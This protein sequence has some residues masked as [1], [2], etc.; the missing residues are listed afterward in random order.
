VNWRR[1]VWVL[2]VF[3][4]GLALHNFA[5]AELWAAGVR[6]AGLSVVSAWKEVLLALALVLVVRERRRLPFDGRLTDWLALL[7]GAFVVLYA[8]I[9]QSWLD[10]GATHK[11]VLFGLRNDLIPV[12]AYFLGR[13]L[14]LTQAEIRRLATTILA[15]GVGVAAFGLID[16]FAIPLSWWRGSGAPNWYAYQ[17]GLTDPG[18]SNLPQNF[19]YNTGNGHPIRRLVSTFL[20]P[21]PSSYLLVVALLLMAAWWVRARPRGGR[22]AVAFAATLSLLFAGLL[23]THSR[24]SYIALALGLLVFATVRRQGRLVVIG[25]AVAVVVIGAVFVKAYP[26]IAPATTFTPKELSIQEQEAK[27][28]GPAVSSSGAT[29]ASTTSHWR[30][31]KSGIK[32]VVD[33]PQG[34][35]LGNA[36]STAARTDV[37]IKAGESTYTEVGVDTGLLGA[38]VFVAWSL[39]LLWEVLRC[40]WAWIGGSLVA[41][42]AL[43]LQTDVIGVPWLTYVIWALAGT[44]VYRTEL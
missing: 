38:L 8:V 41:V 12:G 18:L 9:P 16:I 29:D 34:F 7:F 6:G 21:L 15:T 40:R 14:A 33:H 24:S 23:W 1:P 20:S 11:G 35:G 37:T 32:T 2:H 13:G 5:M 26:H 17:L 10:G 43:A 3:V 44:A 22:A 39:A 42:L 25:A 19:I 30:N 28:A 27:G 31:L 36:G 4:V